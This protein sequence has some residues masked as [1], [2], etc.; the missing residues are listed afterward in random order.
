MNKNRSSESD[1]YNQ[2]GNPNEVTVTEAPSKHTVEADV[3]YDKRASGPGF[4][5]KLKEL[6]LKVV[7]DV[8]GVQKIWY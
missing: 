8:E 3:F 6:K 2:L 1:F 7:K 5:K 4:A